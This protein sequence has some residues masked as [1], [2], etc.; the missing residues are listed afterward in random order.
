MAYAPRTARGMPNGRGTGLWSR[1]VDGRGTGCWS[2]PFGKRSCSQDH[3]KDIDASLNAIDKVINDSISDGDSPFYSCWGL[4][5]TKQNAI[6]WE[7]V[8]D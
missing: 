7:V 2:C 3:I 8:Y 4:C 6:L 5:K 1:R